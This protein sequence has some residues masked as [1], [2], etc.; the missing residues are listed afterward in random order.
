MQLLTQD[1]LV[2]TLLAPYERLAKQ[3]S[4]ALD[5]ILFKPST[6]PLSSTLR[7]FRHGYYIVAAIT[8]VTLIADLGLNIVIS[9][10]PYAKG[11]TWRQS[12]VS[13]YMALGILGFMVL[14][15]VS[16]LVSRLRGLRL[17]RQPDNLG[18]VM[19][20][21]AAG[22]LSTQVEKSESVAKD[23]GELD[24]GVLQTEYE[25]TEIIRDDGTCAWT[26][27]AV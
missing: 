24:E 21:L 1:R 9:G 18:A 4:P 25:L 10:V 22:D 23:G 2:T 12:K 3:P 17:P 16:L 6:T 20:Y 7:A 26:V 5:T 15:A 27:H 13:F 14:V 11:Q 19:S 8:I